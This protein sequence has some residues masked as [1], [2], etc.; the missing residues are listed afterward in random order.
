MGK[1]E[2]AYIGFMIKR[3][4]EVCEIFF[5]SDDFKDESM[6][7]SGFSMMLE[8]GWAAVFRRP[9]SLSA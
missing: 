6:A 2:M 3:K 5:G 9:S 7:I 8:R 1:T 4:F